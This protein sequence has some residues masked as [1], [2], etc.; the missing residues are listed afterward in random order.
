VIG[1]KLNGGGPSVKKPT[2]LCQFFSRNGNCKFGAN[3]KFRHEGGGTPKPKMKVRF[4]RKEKKQVNALKANITKDVDNLDQDAIDE[5]VLGFLTVRVTTCD[6][7]AEETRMVNSLNVQF[8]DMDSFAYDTGAGEGIST[9]IKDFVFLDTSIESKKSIQ[10]N[11]PSVGTPT[12]LGRGPLIFT[13]LR[14]RD[15]IAEGLLI[16]IQ[17]SSR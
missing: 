1:G 17:T 15:N 8:F 4:S 5:M 3:C 14:G 2:G 9:S 11:G 7:V 6:V 13:L 16:V 10:I 12:C